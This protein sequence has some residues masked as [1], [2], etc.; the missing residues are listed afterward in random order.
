M[1]FAALRRVRP[2]VRPY[3]RQMVTMLVAAMAGLGAATIVPLVIK[4]VIDGPI[5][6]HQPGGVWALAGLA[7]L[8]GVIEAGCASIRRWVLAPAALGMETAMRNELY[9]HL[10]RL[11]MSFHDDW[12]SGQLLSRAMADISTIRRFIGFGLIFLFVNTATF[13]MVVGL[14]AVLCWP[15]A[16]VVALSAV[17]IILLSREFERR[18]MAVS[19]RVQ[20]QVGDL[21]TLVEEAAVGIRVT[22]A[23]GRG[24]LLGN[25]FA[26]QAAVL[27][28]SAL[29]RV[30]LL[31]RFWA[32]LDAVPNL[33]LA[34]VLL[35]GAWFVASGA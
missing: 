3:D 17:P 32:A 28:D 24:R 23:F 31:G 1:R 13:L 10:Q 12:Q 15:L 7:L 18:Y 35:G 11:P 19:R 2:Y 5:A 25:R 20:D 8:L 9:A 21:T 16:I 22:K 33:T 29:E 14:L 30:S 27:R 6:D 34:V 4:R 26:R